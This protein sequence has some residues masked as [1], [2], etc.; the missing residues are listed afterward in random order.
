VQAPLHPMIPACNSLGDP[1]RL[2]ALRRL[3]LLDSAPEAGFDRITRLARQFLDAPVAL[4]SLVE[5]KRQFFK[6]A[7]GLGGVAGETRQ[8]PLTH[9]FCQHVVISGQPL[10]VADAREHLLL[11]DN[12]AIED[13]G[14][15]AYL[16]Y[17]ICSPDGA[18]LGSFCVIDTKPRTWTRPEIVLVGELTE[19]VMTE[20][21]ARWRDLKTALELEKRAV[22]LEK[23]N[24]ILAQ[25]SQ[26]HRAILDG[27]VYGIIGTAADGKI[28]FFNTGAENMLGYQRE[29]LVGRKTPTVIHAREEMVERAAQLS[30]E[31]GRTVEPGFE[32]FAALAERGGASESEWTYVRKDGSRLPVSLS[33]TA[34]RG[35]RGEITGFLG[36]AQD[37]TA[38]KKIE[39]TLATESDL[40][41]AL[42]DNSTD[43]IYFKDRESRFIK[44]NNA[45]ARLFGAA[46]P[47][48][49]IG[50]TDFDFFTETHARTAYADEQEV[51]R[52]GRA[53]IGKE[54]REFLLNN[55]K[56]AWV[57]TSKM[58]LHNKEGEIVGTF[59]IS[60]DITGLKRTEL[61]LKEAKEEAEAATRAKSEFLANVSHEIRTPMNGII[62]M[63]GLLM[64]T[65]LNPEQMEMGQVIHAS[66]ETLLEIINNTLDF[67][68]LEAGKLVMEMIE[69]DLRQV[70][71]ETL[72]LLAPTAQKK[73]LE[74]VGDIDPQMNPCLMGDAGRI[75]QVLMNLT[76]NAIKFT[77]SGEV[78]AR[79]LQRD[80]EGGRVSVRFEVSDTGIG[81]PPEVR[82]KLFH[83]FTQVDGS[84]TRRF[85]GTGLGLAISRQLVE[86]MGGTIGFESEVGR[87][88][89]FWFELEFPAAPVPAAPVQ[90]RE[91]RLLVVD[92]NS[93][94]RRVL[95]AQLA[96][97][98]FATEGAGDAATALARLRAEAGGPGA[99][100]AA[101]LDWHMPGRDAFSI[102]AEIRS[103]AMLAEMPLVLLS[104]VGV[105]P[106]QAET[107]VIEFD[108]FLTKPVRGMR[109][110]RCLERIL[111]GQTQEPAMMKKDEEPPAAG[112]GLKLLVVDDNPANLLVARRLLEHA[113]HKVDVA[114]NGQQALLD[115]AEKSY[116]GVFMDCQMPGLDGFEAT[117]RIRSG[118]IAGVNARVPII[119][120]TAAAMANARAECL[121]A[122]MNEYVSKPIHIEDLTAAMSRCGLRFEREPGVK[123][124]MEDKP[125]GKGKILDDEIV[126][127]MKILPGRT[128]RSLWP[129]LVAVFRKDDLVRRD[130]LARLVAEKR[131]DELVRLAHTV[132]GSCASVGAIEAGELISTIERAAHAQNWGEV[133]AKM[134]ELPAVW[135]RLEIALAATT[136]EAP[137]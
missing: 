69:L 5:D 41:Q 44:S 13:L 84:T 60:K 88:S 57:L 33:I 67:S 2:A 126:G 19:L 28:Q 46:S 97:L 53:I 68:K 91:G 113:G 93:I 106:D 123:P 8:T 101:L 1:A 79:V 36:I 10:V 66:A 56:E 96:A 131:G 3:N 122:G 80:A 61:A 38:R 6:A 107:T 15:V 110:Q 108:G 115:L 63:A 77:E 49:L 27:T 22:E 21:A 17:P 125:A 105:R 134:G 117:R 86:L 40:W 47:K 78:V 37:L 7:S 62:G 89:V 52:T 30:A 9:S 58:P 130:A 75:R 76:G 4:V 14:V 73:K 59:G 82:T 55:Q 24:A 94:S 99:F 34:L 129:E 132:A 95:L 64:E 81:I 119:A 121:E 111:G 83:A 51:I 45:H 48:E 98:G 74:L 92:D 109:L 20:I 25:I 23:T 136:P 71:E 70:V 118:K 54:E 50:K 104:P 29:E 133:A 32:V 137:S 11:R 26:L 18:V 87:G 102:A 16:G 65:P 116:D 31:L 103:D 85:G 128:G 120:L 42:L 43:Y 112:S 35:D 90:S 127:R 12:L 135:R 100:T 39:A 114:K 72:V 124:A